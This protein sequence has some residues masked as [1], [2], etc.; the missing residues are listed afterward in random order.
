MFNKTVYTSPSLKSSSKFS[1]VLG[2]PASFKCLLTHLL[3]NSSTGTLVAKSSLVSPS[4]T[5]SSASG[6]S[7]MTFG[8][9]KTLPNTSPKISCPFF[10]LPLLISPGLILVG[11]PNFCNPSQA[12]SKLAAWSLSEVFGPAL[13][14]SL[15]IKVRSA[16][17]TNFPKITPS[18][19]LFKTSLLSL[20]IGIKY[21]QGASSLSSF[22]YYINISL[23]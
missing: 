11:H 12:N 7:L 16:K 15:S 22:F 2:W 3:R 20:S 10:F 23:H 21:L 5:K 8:G 17:H 13:I 9:T 18:L 4:K 1:T 6:S 19:N 14:L